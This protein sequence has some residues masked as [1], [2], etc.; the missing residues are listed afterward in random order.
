MEGVA[1]PESANNAGSCSQFIPLLAFGIPPGP[2]LAMLLGALMMYGLQPGP[3]LWTE[4][5]Q[6][7]WSTIASMYIETWCS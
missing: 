2:T 7:V 3:R 4:Q 1:G 5:P 6:L